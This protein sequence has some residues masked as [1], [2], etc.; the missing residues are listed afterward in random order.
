MTLDKKLLLAVAIVLLVL[1]YIFLFNTDYE[2][3]DAF[4][5]AKFFV[6][7]ILLMLHFIMNMGDEKEVF[8]RRSDYFV[9][10]FFFPAILI[11]GIGTVFVIKHIGGYIGKMLDKLKN[12]E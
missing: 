7:V 5:T 4:I 9:I 11:F 10:P 8:E 6:S 3:M 12:I 2:K 1:Q